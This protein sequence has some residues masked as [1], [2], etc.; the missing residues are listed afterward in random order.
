MYRVVVKRQIQEWVN[1]VNNKKNQE[2]LI[3]Y[4]SSPESRGR[5]GGILKI[6]SMGGNIY[7][8]IKS[9]FNIKR[10]RCFKLRFSSNDDKTAESW[11]DLF[12]LIKEGILTSFNQQ[13]LQTDE[14]TRRL[15]QQRLMPG[16]NYCQYFIMKE[17]LAY[18]FE[19]MTLFDEA[20]LIYDE[21]EA[22][23]FQTLSEQGGPW[24]TTF[25][26]TAP[27]DDSNGILNVNLKPYRDT[28]MQNTITI[29]DFRIYLFA[30]QCALLM[31]LNA[32]LELCERAKM[33]ITQFAR[34]IKENKVSLI[35]YFCESWVYSACLDVVTHSDE[36]VAHMNMAPEIMTLYEGVK[37]DLLVYAR[38]QLDTL[39]VAHKL[40][41]YSIHACLPPKD[42]GNG[43]QSTYLATDSAAGGGPEGD[44]TN[45]E[46]KQALVS[47]EAF[48]ELYMQKIRA[49]SVKPATILVQR[50]TGRAIK[51]LESSMRVRSMWLMKGDI[52][53]LHYARSRLLEAS[54]VWESMVYNY[55][56]NGW[57]DL[58]TIILERLSEC[59]KQLGQLHKYVESCM[60]LMANSA[61]LSAERVSEFV[62]DVGEVAG[63]MDSPVVRHND[64]VF[65]VQVLSLID[66]IADDDGIIVEIEV[67]SSLP[68]DFKFSDMALVF[69]GEESH[70]FRCNLSDV[71][72]RPG[73]NVL[74]LLGDR[75]AAPGNYS[76]ERLKMQIG[77]LQFRYT[78]HDPR[79]RKRLFYIGESV[80]SLKVF[81]GMPDKCT[82][83]DT[84]TSFTVRVYTGHNT[85]SSG[86]MTI[87]VISGATLPVM[88][89]VLFR[90]TSSLEGNAPIAKE[91][92]I[93]T[94][95]GKLSLPASAENDVVEFSV[96][97]VTEV[98]KGDGKSGA[99][100]IKLKVTLNYTTGDGRR[101]L[102]STTETVKLVWGLGIDHSVE[103]TGAGPWLQFAITGNEQT[104]MRIV[105]V[106]LN[107]TTLFEAK[108]FGKVEETTLFQHQHA[109]VLYRLSTK[110]ASTPELE[111]FIQ[112]HLDI[113]IES[114]GMKRYAGFLT[115]FIRSHIVSHLDAVDYAMRDVLKVPVCERN[116]VEGS[117]KGEDA[118][119]KE[120]VWA[121]VES[122]VEAIQGVAADQ[123][124]KVVRVRPK[125][126]TYVLDPPVC[127][128]LIESELRVSM[129]MSIGTV[130]A[131]KITVRVGV[132]DSGTLPSGV[133]ISY[134]MDVDYGCWMVAGRKRG[135]IN[136]K[137]DDEPITIFVSLV[138]LIAGRILLPR[139]IMTLHH[140]AG[141]SGAVSEQVA[142]TVHLVHTNPSE[143]VLVLPR[144]QSTRTLIKDRDFGVT[145]WAPGVVLVNPT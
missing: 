128:V 80:T 71:T 83:G 26:G 39:G 48:D 93:E 103:Q 52:A 27:G 96:P 121:V 9:D 98:G 104:P 118:E 55:S 22:Y 65:R 131:S 49:R 35:P 108:R 112:H 32:P 126:L 73:S 46:L 143:Q 42:N 6:G 127:K 114:H 115:H 60:Y 101:R 145:K 5:A 19:L 20:L 123:V 78:L 62:K 100:E 90:T 119:V 43:T 117:V 116:V 109:S 88:K 92:N 79:R 1:I 2:W 97:F 4:V 40:L 111:Q 59:Q 81:V 31:K 87:N 124:R 106:D 68:S 137:P 125:V 122:F 129:P 57:Y 54:E 64:Q 47:T 7:E 50:F 139:I 77:K 141:A 24:F 3:V 132:W 53:H 133:E 29:F 51:S 134:D 10:D 15:D 21:L 89:S 63:R 17:G 91:Q 72:L 58:D 70:Q 74:K 140:S 69:S 44:I 142:S 113:S 76:A 25:G 45:L 84:P 38:T 67:H 37:A 18:T 66:K 86:T 61:L 94:V 135:V 75:T 82:Y 95:E 136:I 8:K 36:L 30:R 23:F 144:T 138:P 13:I 102:Q 105:G 110:E 11:N 41:P 34:T 107:P 130:I 120:K 28:I 12:S 33:F 99:T 85:I 56:S 14:D 16:W